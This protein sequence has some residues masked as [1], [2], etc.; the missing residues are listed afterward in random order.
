M[1]HHILF[2]H[3]E[4]EC[5]TPSKQYHSKKK[6]DK[7]LFNLFIKNEKTENS[8]KS[9]QMNRRLQKKP[10][11]QSMNNLSEGSVYVNDL[12]TKN[13]IEARKGLRLSPSK[14]LKEVAICQSEYDGLI[15][16]HK[17]IYYADFNNRLVLDNI[18]LPTFGKLESLKQDVVSAK[19]LPAIQMAVESKQVHML[20]VNQVEDRDDIKLVRQLLGNKGKNIK[21]MAKI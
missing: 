4:D 15:K 16:I 13:A 17:H 1:N 10:S 8:R 2:P 18:A 3:I 11:S 14:L 20:S 7:F 19:D 6:Q 9:L 5:D 21:I 12:I